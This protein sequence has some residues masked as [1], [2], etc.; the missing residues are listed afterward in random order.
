MTLT[1]IV[2]LVVLGFFA[3]RYVVV[4]NEINKIGRSSSELET[5]IASLRHDY[6]HAVLKWESLVDRETLKRKL[7]EQRSQLIQIK[8]D[9]LLT[10]PERPLSTPINVTKP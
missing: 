6:N 2:V 10:V 1:M 3:I 5:E 8:P 4:L 7:I 9:T